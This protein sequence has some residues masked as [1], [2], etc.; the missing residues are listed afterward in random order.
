MQKL[1]ILIVGISNFLNAFEVNTH[2]ALTRCAIT[3][4]CGNGTSKN[5][6]VFIKH[7]DIKGQSYG[8]EIFENYSKTYRQYANDGLGFGD[9]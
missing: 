7:G 8:N 5:L 4:S 6:Y 9:W 1:L 3:S 2:Q